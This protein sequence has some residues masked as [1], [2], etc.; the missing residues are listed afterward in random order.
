[1]EELQEALQ[2]L[3]KY[4]PVG[5]LKSAVDED[6]KLMIN[7]SGT[8]IILTKEGIIEDAFFDNGEYFFRLHSFT[9]ES[10]KEYRLG[11]TLVSE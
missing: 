11:D 10:K 4:L 9:S 2:I 8:H 7:I 5:L 1:M 6:G 3:K